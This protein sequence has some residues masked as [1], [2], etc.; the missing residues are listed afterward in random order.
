MDGWMDG[1]MDR[2]MKAVVMDTCV[3]CLLMLGVFSNVL[4]FHVF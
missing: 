2:W 3:R 4:D 1:W